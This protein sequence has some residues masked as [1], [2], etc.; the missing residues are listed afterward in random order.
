MTRTL[1]YFCTGLLLL[2][3][4]TAAIRAIR[5]GDFSLTADMPPAMA[6]EPLAGGEVD[7]NYFFSFRRDSWT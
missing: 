3:A 1:H 7:E 4:T 6:L 2:A 5:D